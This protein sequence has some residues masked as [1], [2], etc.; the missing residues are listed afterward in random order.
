MTD[1]LARIAAGLLLFVAA[2]AQP[3]TSAAP[4][5]YVQVPAGSS[6]TFTFTQLDAAS[7]GRFRKFQTELAYDEK[8]L[9]ASS[10]KV[11]EV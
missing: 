6:L 7:T 10:L 11:S 2:V 1:H 4:A 5:R 8:N 3:A 9:A